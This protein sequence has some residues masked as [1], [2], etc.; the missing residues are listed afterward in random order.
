MFWDYLD[1]TLNG[2]HSANS[3]VTYPHPDDLPD[4]FSEAVQLDP[5]DEP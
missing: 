4:R 2:R 1:D 5:L 3:A